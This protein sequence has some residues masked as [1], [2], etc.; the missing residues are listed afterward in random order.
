MNGRDFLPL[1]RR[2]VHGLD[3]ASHDP[4]RTD[5]SEALKFYERD[6]LHEGTWHP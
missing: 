3:T 4:M 5:I 2:L 6:V 1:S